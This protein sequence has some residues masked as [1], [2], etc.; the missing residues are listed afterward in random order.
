MVIAIFWIAIKSRDRLKTTP[1]AVCGSQKELRRM[2]IV[3]F[4]QQMIIC[5][6]NCNSCIGK[7]MNTLDKIRLVTEMPFNKKGK[8]YS[9]PRSTPM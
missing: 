5:Q 2:Y 6:I 3:F 4:A 7:C 1:I 9:F 8:M